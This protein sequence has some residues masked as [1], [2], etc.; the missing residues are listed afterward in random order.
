MKKPTLI[1]IAG[2]NSF[3]NLCDS[4]ALVRLDMRY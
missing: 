4:V 3:T 2:P 1:I